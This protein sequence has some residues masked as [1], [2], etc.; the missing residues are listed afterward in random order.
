MP[1]LILWLYRRLFPTKNFKRITW[2]LISI[3]LAWAIADIFVTI[4]Y[5]CHPID[6]FW[7]Q[8][9][10]HGTCEAKLQDYY[11]TKEILG[12]IIETANL[13]LPVPVIVK[14]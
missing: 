9:T 1:Y 2:L 5:S 8:L 10:E 14:L 12:T 13:G 7:K 3:C 4:F 11:V 6:Y